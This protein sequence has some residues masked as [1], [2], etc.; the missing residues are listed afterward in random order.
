MTLQLTR[1]TNRPS[2]RLPSTPCPCLFTTL[3]ALILLGMSGCTRTPNAPTTS[4]FLFTQLGPSTKDVIQQLNGSD[5]P[6]WIVDVKSTG[7][8]LL[9]MT[10]DGDLA[11]LL[12]CG[13]NLE[14]WNRNEPGFSPLLY[15]IDD[16]L[17]L[18]PIADSAG[19]PALNWTSGCAATDLDGDGDDDLLLTGIE[20]SLLLR[21]DNGTF[22]PVHDSGIVTNSWCTSAAFGDLDLD[23]DLDLFICRYLD[24]PFDSPPENGDEWSCLWENQPVLCGPRGLPASRD[25]VFENLGDW[26]FVDRTEDW[27]FGNSTPGYGLA[28]T[29]I[30]LYGD[31][32]PEIFVANDSCPNH[33]WSRQ[34]DETWLEDGLLSGLGVDQDGQ[35]QAGMGIAVAGL[36]SSGGLDLA[37]TNFE[38]ESVNL[39]QNQGDG[40]FQDT[41]SRS[42]LS[43]LTRSSLGWGLGIADF[44]LNGTPDLFICNGHVYPQADQAEVSPG[45][46]QLDQ[47]LMG[48]RTKEGNLLFKEMSQQIENQTRHVGRCLILSDL[49]RDGDVDAISSSLNGS[50]HIYRNNI[51]PN[52]GN[53]IFSATVKLRQKEPNLH[54]I[55][56][57]IRILDTANSVEYPVLRNSSFQSTGLSTVT[58]PLN[59][60]KE[61]QYVEIKWPD[62]S[63]ELFPINKGYQ[64][65]DKGRGQ[66]P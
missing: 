21:N 45:Y 56:S 18:D 3:L 23:G 28:V 40:T 11:L 47:L 9:D 34:A 55:G 10:G 33:L 44:D 4:P 53:G 61:P 48:S 29:I 2:R 52:K 41:A 65:L 26:K 66:K 64:I 42:G 7:M 58:L 6:Q 35:E 39:Y 19:I 25:L 59:G 50:P 43:A 32:H 30:D 14:R 17:D 54:A 22:V 1:L 60:E 24:F 51:N 31:P 57:T 16:Q 36:D 62:G 8:A 49:D 13:S 12:T 27:G 46:R 37:V 20:G 5:P 15:R 63:K 38:R